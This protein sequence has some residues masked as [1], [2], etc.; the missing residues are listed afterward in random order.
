VIPIKEFNLNEALE[1]V[2]FKIGPD[3]FHAVPAGRLPALAQL[4]YSQQVAA[5]N[6]YEAHVRFFRDA[7]EDEYTDKFLERLDSKGNPITLHT[8][9]EV[10][11]WL[12]G[13]VYAGTPTAPSSP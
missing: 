13:D 7:L 4:R 1:S 8:M 2:P 3:V 9:A 12:I 6:L 11:N 10:A 5:G